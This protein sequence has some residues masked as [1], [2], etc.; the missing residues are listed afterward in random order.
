MFLNSPDLLPIENCWNLIKDKVKLRHCH[1]VNELI[2]AIKYVWAT[3]ITPDYCKRPI[4]SM[5]RRLELC[6][7]NK[8]GPIKYWCFDQWCNVIKQFL[9][10]CSL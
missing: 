8:G 5:P 3:E 4:D 7:A 1:S 10:F 9:L 6:L 2:E